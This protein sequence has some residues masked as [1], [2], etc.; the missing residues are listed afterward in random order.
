VGPGGTRFGSAVAAPARP[1]S[2]G[3]NWLYL[4]VSII[5]AV[6][7]IGSFLITGLLGI[8]GGRQ[9]TGSSDEYVEGTGVEHEILPTRNHVAEPQT[10][11]YNS[12][13]AT[14]GDHWAQWS[15]CGFFEEE[16]PDERIV[17]N[18]EHSNIVVSYNLSTP[19]QIDQLRDVM[20]DIGLAN[21]SGITRAYSKIPVGTVALAAWGVSDTMEGIDKDRIENFFNTYAGNLGPEGNIPCLN[22]GV[23]P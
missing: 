4:A 12:I 10:V 5:I 8:S 7:V 22:S 6:L 15:N 3:K 23:M 20:E 18:L 16:L 14:S 2:K 9:Q 11:E 19:E 1:R 13:P 17:H 21:T